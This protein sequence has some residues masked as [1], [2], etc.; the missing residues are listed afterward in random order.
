VGGGSTRTTTNGSATDVALVARI[1]AGD[2][3]ALAALYDRY[4]SLVYGLA[5]AVTGREAP[6]GDAVAASFRRVWNEAPRFDA[7]HTSV[8]AWL[9]TM[10]RREALSLRTDGDRPAA[11]PLERESEVARFTE[12]RAVAPHPADG[13]AGP[14]PLRAEVA[15]ALGGLSPLERRALELAFFR[16]LAVPEIALQLEEQEYHIGTQLRSAM[17]H[18]RVALSTGSAL[19]QEQPV[20]RA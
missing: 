14:A 11:V 12:T 4:A 17:E 13:D 20:T 7:S 8:A 1:A 18:L 10:V 15:L 5:Y 16:G 2:E 6:A 19:N 3:G 9:T